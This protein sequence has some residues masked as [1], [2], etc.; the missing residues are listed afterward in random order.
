METDPLAIF[1]HS[2]ARRLFLVTELSA[3]Y[4]R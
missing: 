3:K 2:G 4:L 1:F